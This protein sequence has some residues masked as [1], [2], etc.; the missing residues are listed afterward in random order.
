MT[1]PRPTIDPLVEPGAAAHEG[2]VLDDDRARAGRL[3]H[4]AD[5]DPGREVDVAADLGAGAHEDVRIDHRALAR[6][7]RP[8]L[9]KAGGMMATPGR[10]VGAAPDAR[11]AGHD[12]PGRTGL[13]RRPGAAG[14]RGRR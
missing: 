4:A 14:R 2:A 3:E 13:G 10:E 9:T 1:A 8:L 5:L 12:A 6:P 11:P 7:R